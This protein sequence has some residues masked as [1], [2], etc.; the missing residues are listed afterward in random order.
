MPITAYNDS[1]HTVI[2]K[3][4]TIFINITPITC[5]NP[6]NAI[7]NFENSPVFFFITP[8]AIN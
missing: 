1:L 6:T 4:N 5:V 3:H 7:F 2:K 8:I